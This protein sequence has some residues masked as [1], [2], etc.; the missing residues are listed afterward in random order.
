[1]R[2]CS[3]QCWAALVALTQVVFFALVADRALAEEIRYVPQLGLT[4]LAPTKVSFNPR[5]AQT[6]MV[7]NRN[8][9]I[10]LI[11]V[12]NPD[13]PIKM[14]EIHAGARDAAFNPAGDRI[15][16]GGLDG[17]VRLWT[18]DGQ[19]AAAPFEGHEGR[20]TSVAFNPAGDRIVSGGRDG[21]VRLWTL[22]GQAAAAP[23]EGHEGQVTSVAFNPAGDRIVS[24]GWDGTVRL[25]TLGGQAAA[26]PFRG[27]EGWVTSV[28]FNPAGDRI[29]SGGG[30]GTVRLWTLDGQAAAAPFE[31]HK[32]SVT[33]V[34][35]N[36][37]GDRIVS[38]G[39]DGTVRLWTLDGQAAVAAFEGHEGRV[40]S[41]AF[42]PAG[43]RIVSGGIDGTVRLWT[44]DGQAAVTPF[45]SHEGWVTSVAFNPAGDRIVSGGLDGTIRFWTLGGKAAAAA[46]EGHAGRVWS[47]AFNPPGD[48][49]VSGG[50]DGTVR[51]WDIASGESDAALLCMANSIQPIAGRGYAVFCSDRFVLLYAEFKKR[52]ELFLHRD[53]FVIVTGEGVFAASDELQFLVRGFGEDGSML[54][55]RGAVPALTLARARQILFDDW[56]IWERVVNAAATRYRAATDAYYR[57]GWAKVPFWPALGWVLA[58][59]SAL[60]VWILAPARLAHWAMPVAGAPPPPPWKW[61]VGVIT[62]Y[63][64]LGVTRRPLRAW[65]LKHRARLEAACFTARAPVKQRERYAPL[66]H[67]ELIRSF[68]AKIRAYGRGLIWIDGV[69][70]S[71]KSALAF[72]IVR[73][74]LV[75]R[76]HAPVPVLVDE[77]WQGSLASQVAGQLR[78]AEWDRGPTEAMAK[79]LGAA[80]LVCPVLDSLSERA[81]TDAA[82]R[83]GKALSEGHFRHLVVTS[84]EAPAQGQVWHWMDRVSTRALARED[85]PAFV[86]AYAPEERRAEVE[87]RIAPLVN[88]PTMP[89]PLFLRFAIEQA[90]EGRLGSTE[91][92]DLVL[93][94]VEALRA[95]RV[96]LSAD[97]MARA[98]W[99]TAVEAVR[100]HESLVR[101]EIEQS[102]LRGVLVS[103]ADETPFMD[104]RNASKVD[105]AA[106]I[107]KLVSSGLLQRNPANKRIRFTN[108]LIAEILAASPTVQ[109]IT[110]SRYE[111]GTQPILPTLYLQQ[112]D[113]QNVRCFRSVRLDFKQNG[114]LE[115]RLRTIILGDNAM[116]KS[117][118]LRSI[119]LALCDES[120]AI[121]LIKEIPG[122]IIR[123]GES[124][125]TIRL[126]LIEDKSGQQLEIVN[127]IV[128]GKDG[129]EVLR[130]K[131]N[132]ADFPW[133]SIFMCGYGTQR[134]AAASASFEDYSARLAVSTLIDVRAVLQ[135]PE[136][137][138]LR[139]NPS[140]RRLFQRKLLDVLLLD[141]ESGAVENTEAG[142]I[143]RGPWG[144]VPLD[145]LSD[146]YRSTTQWLLDLFSWLVHAERLLADSDPAGIL[147]ID[148]LEQHLHPR[149]QRHIMQRLSRQLSRMQIITST[150]TP[151]IASGMAD[152]ESSGLLRLYKGD[153]DDVEMEAIEPSRLQGKRADQVLTEFFDLVTSRNPGSSDDLTRYVE[154]R[155]KPHLDSEENSELAELAERFE[156]LLRFGESEFERTV[157]EAVSAALDDMLQRPPEEKLSI[158]AKRQLREL[159]RDKEEWK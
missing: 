121:A 87:D 12:S 130:Q 150:H 142:L 69:G 86:A 72:H 13:R 158:E 101:G 90:L 139:Q 42:N 91:K 62:F 68:D 11:D 113:I 99:I 102:F 40:T 47:V 21:T 88:E 43:D 49:I 6:L 57:L 61:L 85:V 144:S 138:M 146:G 78:L 157:E 34:A 141:A 83:V 98:A 135:N 128:R 3:S 19:A 4:E 129:S 104:A 84:R 112:V 23:F 7:V 18:L 15:V 108:D 137:V 46:F 145:V 14:L 123:E 30:D 41:V 50:E 20:V 120:N 131:T 70:G 155:S 76:R 96:D 64:W 39:R 94:H 140:L 132:P 110:V 65:L 109:A 97:D 59:L 152:V 36:P 95:G 16:S 156:S 37:A 134:T 5:D 114:E 117:T 10:D 32:N 105:P 8:G 107:E 133:E 119:A 29:V 53:G 38:G 67:Y 80:G 92:L 73:E 33:S 122:S 149:W 28:A 82:E 2:F 9:R 116:G 143:V 147:L 127:K 56:R 48:R 54:V 66:D 71:G 63:G 58:V 125:A 79:T 75:G 25:W 93:H 153:E 81:M 17:T 103:E 100:E 52:G 60:S 45:E 89:S 77:D 74:T 31:G 27:H 22:G 1:L 106:V 118:L 151:L 24:G 55:R 154:L 51:L 35:F 126:R 111:S 136:V 26:A 124:E 148:E 159:F 44:L 115:P